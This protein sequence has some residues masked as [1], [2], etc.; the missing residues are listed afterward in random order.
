MDGIVIVTNTVNSVITI[1]AS[2]TTP[3][4][5]FML[6]CFGWTLVPDFEYTATM[7]SLYTFGGLVEG[8]KSFAIQKLELLLSSS[9]PAERTIATM[10]LG[11]LIDFHK[12]A[13]SGKLAEIPTVLLTEARLLKKQLGWNVLHFAARSGCLTAVPSHILTEE[14]IMVPTLRGHT[15]LDIA[16]D[17][18]HLDQ[19]LGVQFSDPVRKVVGDVWWEENQRLQKAKLGLQEGDTNPND[20]ELF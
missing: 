12:T 11:N 7:Y 2:I 14:N 8:G 3:F 10:Q 20:L 9:N 4:V 16:L 6:L 1:R 5:I 13:E 18:K 17:Y 19:L 15:T